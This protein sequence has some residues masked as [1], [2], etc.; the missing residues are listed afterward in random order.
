[1]PAYPV[2]AFYYK[3]G[4][5]SLVIF[6]G[7]SRDSS[8]QSQVGGLNSDP[9]TGMIRPPLMN[10]L[11]RNLRRDYLKYTTRDRDR[12]GDS[13]KNLYKRCFIMYSKPL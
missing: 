8:G 12:S 2:L 1:M 5:H 9:R 10:C 4:E 3:N 13:P 11:I 7:P 6:G